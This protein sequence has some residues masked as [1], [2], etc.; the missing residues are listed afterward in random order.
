MN[1]LLQGLVLTAILG[2]SMNSQAKD[3]T[4]L[5]E[6]WGFKQAALIPWGVYPNIRIQK[7]DT[8]VNLPNTWNDKDF[9]SDKGFYRGEGSYQKDLM[10]PESDRG[11]RIFIHFEGVSNVATVFCN[12][13]KV[14]KHNGAYNGFTVELTDQ[15]KYGEKNTIVVICDNTH[16]LDMRPI[17]ADF[18]VYGGIYR[19]VWL[20]KSDENACISPMFYGSNG[21]LV[22]QKS[23]SSSRVHLQTE[24]HLTTKSDYQGCTVEF[25]VIDVNGKIVASE[26][27]SNIYNDKCVINLSVANPHLWQGTADPYLYKVVAVMKRNGKEIDRVED[28]TGFRSYYIDNEKGFFL[29]GQHLKLHGIARHQEWAGIATAL[30]KENHDID[31]NLMEEMGINAMR[32]AHYPQ[33]QYMMDEADR[34]GFVVWEEIPFVSNYIPSE[35]LDENLR[36]DLREMIYQNYNHP[37]ICFWGIFNEVS[38]GHN[39]I[40][41]ELNDM[42]HE[43]DP[44]RLS[45]S[46]TC[47][48]G[49]FNFISDVLG[50][51]KYFGWYNGKNTDLG[52]FLDQWHA[53]HPNTRTCVSEYG[54]GAG[55]HQ[56]IAKAPNEG[57]Y[58]MA[59]SRFH[60]METQ[61]MIHH[62]ALKDISERDFVWGSFL[63]N[64][65][66][67]GS[68]LRQEGE[69]NNLND[70][71]IVS[72]DRKVKKDAFYLYRANWN[73]KSP[74]TYLCSKGYTDRKEDV[75]DVMGFVSDGEATLLINGK[76][77]GSQKADNVHTVIWK[78]VKLNQGENTVVLKSAHGRDEAKWIVK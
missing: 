27:T 29:N 72:H 42:V 62:N 70:K 48:E 76:K 78:D 20:E 22:K 31:L 67:F 50:W 46:A 74:T 23:V 40:A 64:M 34:R 18:N 10:I 3:V 19:D 69:S 8:I 7:C 32:M 39:R 68:S 2:L 45:T 17:S 52:P 58:R 30:K 33:A 51:N 12:W 43:L 73:K 63:W 9:M 16:Q 57:G 24:I 15:V 65:F 71:G 61:T 75:T 53:D 26:T 55:L 54:G 11:K 41:A 1:R 25:S 13:K 28:K 59:L 6:G 77:I 5:N 66:D 38:G 56:H 14:G 47:F 37:S 36:E 35:S 4:S 21:M 49:D 60:P 44:S